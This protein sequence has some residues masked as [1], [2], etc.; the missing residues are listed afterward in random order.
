[1]HGLFASSADWVSTD[2]DIG[3]GKFGVNKN[4]IIFQYKFIGPSDVMTKIFINIQYIYR[5][6]TSRRRV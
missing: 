4:H 1:M 2:R 3:I 6:C 5:F